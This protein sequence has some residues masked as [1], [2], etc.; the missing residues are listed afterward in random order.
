MVVEDNFGW[1]RWFA[2]LVVTPIAQHTEELT[3][4][5]SLSRT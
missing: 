4:Y 5:Y 3:L 2:V 1:L